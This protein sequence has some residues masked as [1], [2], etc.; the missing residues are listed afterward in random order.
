MRIQGTMLKLSLDLD[1]D[2]D[3][4]SASE[5]DKCNSLLGKRT[6]HKDLPVQD[7]TRTV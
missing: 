5:K 3:L 7:S 6:V 4:V 1:L 2:L